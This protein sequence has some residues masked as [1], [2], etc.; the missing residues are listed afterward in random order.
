[1][2]RDGDTLARVSGDEFVIFCEAIRSPD[3]VEQLAERIGKALKSPFST[4][5]R[6]LTITASVG[7]AYAGPGEDITDQLVVNAD[8]AMYQVKRRGG[9]GHQVIDLRHRLPPADDCIV[10]ADVRRALALD[11]LDIAYQPVVRPGDRTIVAVEA[12][13]RWTHPSHGP[14]GPTSIIAIAEQSDLVDDIGEW[15]LRRACRDRRRWLRRHPG[16]DLD[17]AVNVSVRHL[18]QPAFVTTVTEALETFDTSPTALVLEVTENLFIDDNERVRD[19]LDELHRTGIRIALDDYGTGYSSLGYLAHLPIHILKI[20]RCFISD[21]DD[22]AGRIIV[23]SVNKL[24]HDLGLQV[25]AEGVETTAQHDVITTL[26]CDLAQGYLYARP[27]DADAVGALVARR[28][29]VPASTSWPPHS[30]PLAA[31][32]AADSVCTR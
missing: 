4:M 30:S 5:G 3:D 27:M 13:L 18:V 31:R 24:A 23:A 11:E 16:I 32:E 8:L 20:D 9:A 12:L 7:I 21:L 14:V 10:E 17:L 2:V 29:P 22:D 1:L 6:D 19:V 15:V 26:G 25:V 28:T